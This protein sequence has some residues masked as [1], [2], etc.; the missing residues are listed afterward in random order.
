MHRQARSEADPFPWRSPSVSPFGTASFSATSDVLAYASGVAELQLQWMDRRGNSLGRIGEPGDYRQMTLSPDGRRAIVSQG[1]ALWVLDLEREGIA[2]RLTQE[3]LRASDHAWS[4]DGNEIVM[5]GSLSGRSG[6]YRQSLAAGA[7]PELVLASDGSA[8]VDQWLGTDNRAVFHTGVGGTI[9]LLSMDGSGEVEEIVRQQAA[10]DEPHRS[11][12]GKWLAF[13]SLETGRHEIYVEN[14]ETRARVRISREG[15]GQPRW[16]RD[17]RELFFLGLDS[18]V[19][20]VDFD[21]SG[22]PQGIARPLF[23]APLGAVMP[24]SDQWDVHPDGD[25][26]LMLTPAGPDAPY[27]VVLNWQRLLED[28]SSQ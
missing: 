19:M 23:R 6:L 8:F 10:V 11:P 22:G 13:L 4:E 25:R 28:A 12:V 9:A 18:S 1:A 2:S 20:A 27:H 16:R 15:G 26:F 21:P 3:A 14:L 7:E 17:G 24:N 5:T